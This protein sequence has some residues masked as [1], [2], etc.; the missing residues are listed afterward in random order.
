L[1]TFYISDAELENIGYCREGL[2]WIIDG[3]RHRLKE[4]TAEGYYFVRIL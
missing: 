1:Y 4:A 3:K 2:I